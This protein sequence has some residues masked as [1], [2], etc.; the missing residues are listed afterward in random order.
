MQEALAPSDTSAC[1]PR[2]H[3]PY[4]APAFCFTKF[5]ALTLSSLE[6]ALTSAITTS[7]HLQCRECLADPMPKPF[8]N[9]MELYESGS[10]F[11]TRFE[12]ELSGKLCSKMDAQNG[13]IGIRRPNYDLF[14]ISNAVLGMK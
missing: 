1:L 8:C 12:A 10:V 13:Y 2:A 14:F 9:F 11:S 3:S 5:T 6:S 4:D 7:K